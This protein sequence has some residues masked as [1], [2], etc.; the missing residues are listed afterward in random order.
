MGPSAAILTLPSTSSLLGEMAARAT[1]ARGFSG[2]DFTPPIADQAGE[3][4]TT[5]S[6]PLPQQE[7]RIEEATYPMDT[8]SAPNK[9]SE[10]L[11]TIGVVGTEGNQDRVRVN[12][13]LA[14]G[15]AAEAGHVQETG[16]DQDVGDV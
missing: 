16:E 6:E 3:A 15:K 10:T 8:I 7:V 12:H 14:Y 1:P 2:Q 5:M 11:A 4:A 13:V 9:E